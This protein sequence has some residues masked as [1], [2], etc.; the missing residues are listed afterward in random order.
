MTRGKVLSVLGDY[1]MMTVGCILFAIAW[2]A[3]MIPCNMSSGGL[4]G[5]C[6]I[7]QYATGGFLPAS[8]MYVVINA[9]LI[10]VAIIFLGIGFGFKTIYCILMS[11]LCFQLVS[12]MTFMHCVPG[13]FFYI[14]DAVLVPVIGG[15]LEA[16]AI[17]II[18]KRGGSTGGTDIVALMINKYWPVSLS[19]SF[20]VLDFIIISLMLFLPD[21][22]LSDMVYGFEMMITFALTVDVVLSGQK[23][24]VQLMIFSDKYEELA[25]HI[26]HKMDRGV[27]VL[28]A[29]GWYTK[30]D[31]N[32][33]LIMLNQKQLP[34]LTKVI[35]EKDPKA[36]MSVSKT[37]SVYGEGFEEIKTGL[38]RKKKNVDES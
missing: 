2:E 9:V 34:A 33:L 18:L 13:G 6:T 8:I 29:Q 12:G 26:I 14:K 4:M 38:K 15:V 22:A 1:F 16:L 27:T 32:V 36:F 5:L 31:R 19:K 10:L 17:G 3:F 11:S 24:S 25:D 20:L 30:K 35:K 28:K 7:I 21:R 37:S 23:T